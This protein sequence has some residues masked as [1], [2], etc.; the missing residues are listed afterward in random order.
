LV[1]GPDADR[2]E[3]EPERVGPRVH[4]DGVTDADQRGEAFLE[5][6]HG[7]TER[8]VAGGHELPQ[9]GEDQLG[10]REL[11][12]QIGER[13]AHARPAQRWAMLPRQAATTASLVG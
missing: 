2:L 5:R 10:I 12:G 3:A 6:L 9:P 1:A 7:T 4:A 11:L 13:N 8:E